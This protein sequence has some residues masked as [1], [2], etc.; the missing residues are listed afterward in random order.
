MPFD[1]QQIWQTSKWLFPWNQH[2]QDQHI[3][4]L[5]YS[6]K[7]LWISFERSNR[8]SIRFFES[9]TNTNNSCITMLS[10]QFFLETELT[11]DIRFLKNT[12]R[13]F[14]IRFL[15]VFFIVFFRR[16][17]NFDFVLFLF[18]FTKVKNQPSQNIRVLFVVWKQSLVICNILYMTWK[19][20]CQPNKLRLRELKHLIVPRWVPN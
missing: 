9:D 1:D 10:R 17:F 8:N 19:L 6:V 12:F 11:S 5:F 14:F 13:V 2:T 15:V 16:F 7:N 20:E 3:S 18:T 4:S